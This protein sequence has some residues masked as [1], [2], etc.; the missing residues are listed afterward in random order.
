MG[1]NDRR[2]T[3]M[4]KASTVIDTYTGIEIITLGENGKWKERE[5]ERKG[6]HTYLQC[7]FVMSSWTRWRDEL[8]SLH[9]NITARTLAD[10]KRERERE[11]PTGRER[12]RER[13][14]RVREGEREQTYTLE[15]NFRSRKSPEETSV[16]R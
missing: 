5:R 14:G 16:P 10:I 8:L 1:A 3:R 7:I 12:K 15:S 4:Y 13:E 11:R 6:A 9:V 2:D